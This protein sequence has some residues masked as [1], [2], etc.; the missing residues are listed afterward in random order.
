[1]SIMAYYY[2]VKI[3]KNPGIYSSWAECEKQVKGYPN[4]QFKKWKTREEAEAYINGSGNAKPYGSGMSSISFA[5]KTPS[6]RKEKEN[7]TLLPVKDGSLSAIEELFQSTKTDCIA[8][9]DGSF[10]K[11]NGVYGYGVVFIEKNG[12]I[13]EH[14][15]SGREESYQSMRNVSGEILGAL[16]AASLAVEKG[17]SSIAI[18]HDYQG[19]ASWATGEWKCNKEK[20]IEYR[21]KMLEFQKKLIISFH[22]VQAH[23]GDYFNERADLLA[24]L[25]AGISI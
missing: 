23:S 20:T 24:K 9:V 10:E 5:S 2:A 16:K 17:Y 7:A 6:S 4:A 18:F 1:M 19:I 12:T 3:G 22:K 8:Y 15:D 25:A 21:E 11:D 13:E 14:F